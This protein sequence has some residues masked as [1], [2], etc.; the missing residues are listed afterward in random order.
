MAEFGGFE[1][2]A[3]LL[4]NRVLRGGEVRAA[5]RKALLAWLEAIGCEEFLARF[6]TAGYD[7]LGFMAFH[8]LTE[9]DL[10]CVGVP[11]EKLGLR[12]K[13]LAMHGVEPFLPVAEGREE[14][15]GSGEE[16]S[17]PSSWDDRSS[18]GDAS[19]TT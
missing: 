5:N 11:R 8:G 2:V 12:K 13:L 9:A 10:D 7:D 4:K 1:D 15:D 6:F 17:V 3:G 19:D 16:E 18:D 14:H